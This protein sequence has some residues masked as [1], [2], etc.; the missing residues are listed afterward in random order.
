MKIG[1]TERGDG[2]RNLDWIAAC[3][4]RKVDGA[5]IV[6][7]TLTAS[8]GY[9]ML[10]LHNE[11][12][13]LILHATTTGWGGTPM[14]PHVYDYHTQ[15]SAVQHLI[16]KG[17]PAERIVIRVDPIIPSNEGLARAEAVIRTAHNMGLLEKGR[18]RIS[19]LDEYAHTK[20]RMQNRGYTPCYPA[21]QFYASFAQFQ[22][23]AALLDNMH[24]KFG[25]TFE[26]CAE[27]MLDKH[28]TTNC[29]KQTG[30]LSTED[31]LRM[32]LPVPDSFHV[33]GQNRHGCLC[34][35]C[36]TEL[37]SRRHPCANQCAYC[38]WKD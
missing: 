8:C 2:G 37:L 14:E 31:L 21:G 29:L 22:A 28:T 26:T 36:K 34:L 16:Q 19:V 27:P 23:V 12:F 33:N 4:T 9:G 6:T 32:N 13:P 7:K 38:Y 17:F 20:T 11:G 3:K 24:G 18:I 15:L 1:F 10:E 25:L 5:V 30:C 35:T